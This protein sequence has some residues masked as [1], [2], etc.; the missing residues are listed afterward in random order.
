MFQG[1][2]TM[3]KCSPDA[4]FNSALDKAGL[5]YDK[6]AVYKLILL[7]KFTEWGEI[8]GPR[9]STTTMCYYG[10]SEWHI[11]TDND[12]RHATFKEASDDHACKDRAIVWTV[13]VCKLSD[14]QLWEDVCE[15]ELF[16]VD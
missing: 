8:T 16:N 5:S 2:I 15:R 7:T 12:G 9:T 3:G 13:K 11:T 14:E 10:W 4:F 6:T 1:N